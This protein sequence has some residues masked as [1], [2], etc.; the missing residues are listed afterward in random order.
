MTRS[1]FRSDRHLYFKECKIHELREPLSIFMKARLPY[2]I[3]TVIHLVDDYWL[4]WPKVSEM[5][6]EINFPFNYY[7]WPDSDSSADAE[8]SADVLNIL[9]QT[10][11]LKSIYIHENVTNLTSYFSPWGIHKIFWIM[12]DICSQMR[13]EKDHLKN[14]ETLILEEDYISNYTS[15]SRNGK[16]LK[17]VQA[18]FPKV[19]IIIKELRV[20]HISMD[21]ALPFIQSMNFIRLKLNMNHL[22]SEDDKILLETEHLNCERIEFDYSLKYP[23][24]PSYRE[25]SQDFFKDFLLKHHYI[26]DVKLNFYFTEQKQISFQYVFPTITELNISSVPGVTP[27]QSFKCFEMLENLKVLNM[28]PSYQHI[29]E[30]DRHSFGHEPLNLPKL[31]E[32]VYLYEQISCEECLTALANSFPNLIKCQIGPESCRS[33]KPFNL[34]LKNWKYLESLE[35]RFMR[36]ENQI[37]NETLFD[38]IDEPRLHLRKLKLYQKSQRI[39]YKIPDM[40]KLSQL[41]PNL[42]VFEVD[43]HDKVYNLG[44]ITK[45]ILRDAKNL[46]CLK[47]KAKKRVL[48]E[49]LIWNVVGNVKKYGQ[50]LRVRASNVHLNLTLTYLFLVETSFARTNV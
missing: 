25:F 5:I 23:E 35:I 38:G 21:L 17:E 15:P 11:S 27:V 18:M 12:R 37:D 43:L 32:L 44:G 46:V 48:K 14:L 6:T 40:L 47:I 2:D 9:R 20:G 29:P 28:R 1:I 41:F 39:K 19:K 10:K 8:K 13:Y 36:A 24:V 22:K 26:K 16:A 45:T 3:L 50:N 33:I 30:P 42:N 4:H 7:R 34:C 49:Q 31:K